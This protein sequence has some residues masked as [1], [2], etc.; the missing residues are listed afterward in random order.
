MDDKTKKSLDFLG[1]KV[2]RIEKHL[3]NLHFVPYESQEGQVFRFKTKD[4]FEIL[5]VRITTMEEFLSSLNFNPYTLD[6]LS[7]DN[8]EKDPL[9]KEAVRIVCEY[10]RASASLIQRKLAL[11]YVRAQIYLGNWKEMELLEQV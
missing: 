5:F 11:D 10:D 6:D 2:T 9:Y 8:G 3:K 4:P 1:G 7:F